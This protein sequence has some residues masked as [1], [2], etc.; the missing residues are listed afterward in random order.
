MGKNLIQ[1]ARGKA[2]P[3][4]AAPSFRYLGEA[5]LPTVSPA[6]V[7]GTV[8]DLV[9]CQGHLT[10]LMEVKYN[11][12][13]TALL[14]APEGIRVGAEVF[15]G[16][17]APIA[18]GNVLPL[19]DIPEGTLVFNIESTP[20]DGGKFCRTSGTFA[21][22]VGKVGGHVLVLLPSKQEKQIDAK[23]RAMVGIASGAGRKEKPFLKAGHMHFFMKAR[24]KRYPGIS[25]AAQNAVDHPYG[26]KRTSRKA[27][28]K[29]VS[30]HVPA[31]RKVG[32]LWPARTG[33]RK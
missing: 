18:A 27:K 21:K 1:Q 13:Q 3:R 26:N 4:Y 28:N 6:L 8:L 25:A 30:K 33:R 14:Q 16:P 9:R 31:G 15:A 2:G 12:G 10:P 20:G 22:V 32:T 24:N 23:C 7:T 19:S 29:P 11:G 5:R 17:G